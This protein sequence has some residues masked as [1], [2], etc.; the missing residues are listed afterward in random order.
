MLV[1]LLVV[2][3][4]SNSKDDSGLASGLGNN[5]PGS[6]DDSLPDLLANLSPSPDCEGFEGT[7]ITGAT[8]FF[9][10]A[11]T[12]DSNNNISGIEQFI[13][14]ANSSWQAAGQDDCITTYTVTGTL[15]ETSTCAT[16][17]A[18][19]SINAV[20]DGTSSTCP[21][22]LYEDTPSFSVTYDIA[23]SDDG[24]ATWYLLPNLTAQGHHSSTAL[25][26]IT[27]GDCAFF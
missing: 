17:D 15:Q 22:E 3:C 21:E 16:C 20:W 24:T 13:H 7:P 9:Y 12:L 11:F 19:I 14:K 6:A 27:S 26:Y 5:N 25:N 2:G 10:G 8:R 4:Y 18:S 1:F 23:R